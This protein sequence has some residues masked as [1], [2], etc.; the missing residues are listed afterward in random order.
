MGGETICLSKDGNYGFISDGFKGFKIIDLKYLSKLKV[1]G[2]YEITGWKNHL[3]VT[4]DTNYL[5]A[6]TMDYNMI[7]LFDI[8]DKTNPLFLQ[9]L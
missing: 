2:F 4:D 7:S 6:S 9:K 5:I 8:H 1:V 3:E